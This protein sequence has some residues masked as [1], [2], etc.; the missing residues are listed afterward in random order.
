[1][2]R[3]ARPPHS[4]RRFFI[5]NAIAFGV[6]LPACQQAH[7]ADHHLFRPTS[8][9]T[10]SSPVAHDFNHDGRLEI[11]VGSFDGNC[12]LLD[13][14]LRDF[15]GWPRECGG[16]FFSS[17][18]LWDCDR[19]GTPEIFLGGNDGKLHGWRTA[20][21]PVSGFPIDLG[22]QCWSSPVIVADSLIAIGGYEN[23]FL[24]DREGH[25]VPGWPQKIDG[26]A[27]ASAAWHDDLLTIST[28]TRGE[29]SRGWLYAW[30][31]S[32]EAYPNFPVR[33]KMDSD[34]SPV[35]ADLDRNGAMEI[36]VGD[37]A[38]FLHV[39]K[40]DGS[41]LPP[42]PRLAGEA[43]QG[44]VAVADLNRDRLLDF[45][46]G[47]TD[48]AVHVW[49]AL[50]DCALGWPVRTGQE[51]NGSPALVETENGEIRIVI[52]SGDQRL[53][54][55][56]PEGKSE[57]GFPV[58]CGAAIHSSPLVIDLEGNGRYEIVFGANNGIHLLKDVLPAAPAHSGA[59]QWNMF[60]RN[61]QRT[62]MQSNILSF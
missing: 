27:S 9:E 12:Y 31:L 36:I 23:M 46:F 14:S 32:G 40:Q 8:A 54:V 16:G 44:S 18:A 6:G 22:F 45:V 39:F 7:F 42:F 35:L 15:A 38:G 50:G 57:N 52:G 1:M 49:N 37:D 61:A 30:H 17:P 34:S 59:P 43:I 11:I 5:L 56:R 51:I 2:N 19:D 55:L 60:R 20:G 29:T 48:G 25:T 33:L 41:E 13:D 62:G 21:S 24:F 58:D 28:L 4:F 3:P 26:W 53:Y 47:T 10:V